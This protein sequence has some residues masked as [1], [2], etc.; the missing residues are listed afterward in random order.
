[1]VQSAQQQIE[2]TGSSKKT[3]EQSVASSAAAPF[4]VKKTSL[5]SVRTV[6][7]VHI[8]RNNG[9]CRWRLIIF[10]S[11]NRLKKKICRSVRLNFVRPKNLDVYWLQISFRFIVLSVFFSLALLL[12]LLVLY[13]A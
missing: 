1:M 3:Q 9:F 11:C 4:R 12:L 6:G 10:L 8:T 5:F 7:N 13:H 2:H